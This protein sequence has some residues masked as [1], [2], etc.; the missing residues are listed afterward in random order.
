MCSTSTAFRETIENRTIVLSDFFSIL[1]LL[2]TSCRSNEMIL[3]ST[4]EK[5]RP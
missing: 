1:I 3:Q 5:I 2:C 4:V